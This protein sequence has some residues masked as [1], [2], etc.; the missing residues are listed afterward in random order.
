M[1]CVKTW[2]DL[3]ILRFWLGITIASFLAIIGWYNKAEVWLIISAL[4]VLVI[5]CHRSDFATKECAKWLK[6]SIKFRENEVE[7]LVLTCY[8]ILFGDS[9]QR[10]HSDT[11]RR[12]WLREALEQLTHALIFNIIVSSLF[13]WISSKLKTS[14]RSL[15]CRGC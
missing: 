7:Y 14:E 13:K 2:E 5:F 3:I 11:K 10:I 12:R 8:C 4:I 15:K 6:K 9:L 1:A